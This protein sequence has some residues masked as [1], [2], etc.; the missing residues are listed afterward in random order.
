[1]VVIQWCDG[2][3]DEVGVG[4]ES[5]L[6]WGDGMA[7]VVDVVA[8][9]WDDDMVA[10]DEAVIEGVLEWGDGEIGEEEV[11]GRLRSWVDVVL[12]TEMDELGGDM[13]CWVILF[14]FSNL[15]LEDSK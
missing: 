15:I 13:R 9:W 4:D 8:I 10:V 1:M 12:D 3:E 7:D 5:V 14:S 6:R 11:V 2:W